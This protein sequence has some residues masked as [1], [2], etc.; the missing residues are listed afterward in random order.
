MLSCNQP[1]SEQAG[2]TTAIDSLKNDSLTKTNKEK[3]LQ[4]IRQ[5][6]FGGENAEAYFSFDNKKIVFQRTNPKENIFCDQIFYSPLDSFQPKLVSTGK[7]RT[8]C[9]FFLPGDSLIIFSSTHLKSDTCPPVPDRHKI[10]KYVWP[11][12]PSYDIFITDLNGKIKK[13]MTKNN[14]YDAEAT[15]SPKGDKM[16]FTSTR[17]GDIE[18]YTM[19]LNGKNVKQITNELGYDGGAFFSP[20]GNKIIFRA[21]RPKTEEDVKIYKDFLKQN[22]VMPTQMELFICNAD[23]SDLKQLTQFGGANWAPYFYPTGNKI[24][25]SSNKEHTRG[26]PFNLY[27][28]N[29]DGTGLEKI[30]ADENF[31]SFPM[32]S[33]DGRKLI[34][35]SNRENGGT[36][37][38]NLFIADWVE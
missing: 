29:T 14:F 16:V 30:T 8:T 23:G 32:F 33:S 13:Q 25:F 38:T 26:F 17:S 27:M 19:D 11:I 15:V 2:N 22:L 4:N 24:I 18:L 5:L 3:H 28:I 34:F 35:A 1:G 6:T 7:G 31:D 36:R 12:Y 10:G 37:E 9:P 20:D 21:S